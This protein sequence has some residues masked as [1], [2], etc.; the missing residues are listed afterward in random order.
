VPGSA[1]KYWWICSK[2]K[3][4]W[5]TQINVR[6]RSSCPA[7]VGRVASDKNRLLVV[8]KNIA[9]E[10][11]PTKN[12]IPLESLS[13]GMSKRIWWLCKTC[14]HE[15]CTTVNNRVKQGCPSCT[16]KALTLKNQ[17]SNNPLLVKEWH[18]TKNTTTPDKIHM[19][20]NKKAWWKCSV[21]KWEWQ[22]TIGSRQKS[23][24]SSCSGAIV[25][26]KNRLTII[27]PEL[28]NEWHPTKNL[29][30]KPE[31][32]SQG[33]R[34]KVWW[35]CSNKKCQH[36]WFTSISLR[37]KG[38]GCPKCYLPSKLEIRLLAELEY[39][40]GKDNVIHQY[41]CLKYK[42]DV[43]LINHPIAIEFDGYYHIGNEEK[44][45]QRR[46]KIMNEGI[47][48]FSIRDVYLK[49]ITKNDVISQHKER[50][51]KSDIDNLLKLLV[52]NYTK[53]NKSEK[54][55]IKKYL[56]QSDFCNKDQYNKYVFRD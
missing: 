31:D 25:S 29:P 28:I 19:F 48:I 32:I 4:E 55:S 33:S 35:K 51:I 16:G 41:K 43:K 5:E 50:L 15:W 30:L 52:E 54:T 27:H 9:D 38:R 37:S 17:L 47:T 18:P 20:S 42:I 1:K 24:C 40:F 53:F 56:N 23:G 39:V 13:F 10:Y 2:C 3:H 26:D 6:L 12:T 49:P 46:D 7:C 8:N 45:I 44:D 21:C 14:K 36:E 22:A 34:M 11:H